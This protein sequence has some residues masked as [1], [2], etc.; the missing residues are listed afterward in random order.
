MIQLN[1][2]HVKGVTHKLENNYIVKVMSP[3]SGSL[4][5]VSA[6]RRRSTQSIWLCNLTILD[7]RNPKGL[8]ETEKPFLEG[9]HK[10]SCALGPRSKR[11][12]FIV[13]WAR[14]TCWS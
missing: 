5:W 14:P 9:A 4:V 12:N 7:N 8:G 2:I 6:I 11:S 3:T 13:A 1:P 10:I